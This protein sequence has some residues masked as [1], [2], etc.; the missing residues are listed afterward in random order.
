MD[1]LG[2]M[3]VPWTCQWINAVAM[4][5]T[6]IAYSIFTQNREFSSLVAETKQSLTLK[7]P[8]STTWHNPGWNRKWLCIIGYKCY[9]DE[10]E[11]VHNVRMFINRK[12]E[13]G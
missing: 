11:L 10:A 3:D 12:R 2:G 7:Y 13:R 1:Y 4:A 9:R 8:P 5:E 6:F